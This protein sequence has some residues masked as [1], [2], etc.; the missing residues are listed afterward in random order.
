MAV[1]G[2]QDNL[3]RGGVASIGHRNRD[4]APVYIYVLFIYV[5]CS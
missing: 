4:G 2:I 3:H 5:T 1:R